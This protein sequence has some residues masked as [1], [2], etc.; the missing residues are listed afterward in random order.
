MI[1]ILC[2]WN[3]TQCKKMWLNH[4]IICFNFWSREALSDKP[5]EYSYCSIARD[6]H[7]AKSAGYCFCVI[8]SA[9]QKNGML[10]VKRVKERNQRYGRTSLCK[11][12]IEQL[13]VGAKLVTDWATKRKEKKEVFSVNNSNTRKLTVFCQT[14]CEVMFAPIGKIG[15]GKRDQTIKIN[16]DTVKMQ[17]FF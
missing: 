8:V 15:W 11:N 10:V 3:N 9:I 16:I 13:F 14:S 5:C 6:S 17:V 12:W 4:V 7:F 1:I 2:V